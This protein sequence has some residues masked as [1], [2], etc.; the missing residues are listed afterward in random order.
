MNKLR[1][2]LAALALSA[3][4]AVALPTA[5]HADGGC[6]PGNFCV[7]ADDTNYTFAT[8]GNS[9]AW[10]GSV[11][12]KNDWVGNSGYNSGKAQVDIFWGTSGEGY[13]AYACL[14]PGNAWNLRDNSVK[15]GWTK[16]GDSRGLG[17][18]VHDN[19]AAHLWV[20]SCGNNNW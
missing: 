9:G 7:Y 5:A 14:G 3:A 18:K 17:Q 4:T 15:F 16:N 10:P 12:N 1:T 13:G 11:A 20:Y 2:A 6:A 8:Q 19:A